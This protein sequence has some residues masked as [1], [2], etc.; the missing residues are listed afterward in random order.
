NEHAVWG[1]RAVV[2]GMVKDGGGMAV[3]IT[4]AV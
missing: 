4:Q 2:K 3:I 1:P